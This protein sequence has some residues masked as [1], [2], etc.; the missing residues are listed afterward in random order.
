MDGGREGTEGR[1]ETKTPAPIGQQ[2]ARKRGFNKAGHTTRLLF[3]K[4]YKSRHE[5][6]ASQTLV[7]AEESSIVRRR[8]SLSSPA[9]RDEKLSC[10][11][12]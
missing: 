4:V 11:I 10:Q 9:V 6:L 1:G 5:R 2:H 3:T 8:K 12:S 7:A